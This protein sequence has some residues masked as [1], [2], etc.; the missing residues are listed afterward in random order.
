M[1]DLQTKLDRLTRDGE[2]FDKLE[3]GSVACYACGHTCRIA[4]GHRGFCKVRR[5]EN[6]MLKVPWGYVAGLQADPIEKK[7]FAHFFPGATALTYG[8]LGCNLHCDFCQ[9]W[10]T[11]QALRDPASDIS[12]EYIQAV[13]PEQIV[14]AAKRSR[15]VILASSYNEPLITSEWSHAVFS[16]AKSQGLRTVYVSNGFATPDVLEYM[17]PVVDGMKIDLKTMQAAQYRA[18][19]G[20]LSVVLDTISAARAL[21][22]WVEVVTLVIPGFNDSTEELWDAARA[23]TAVSADI[24]WHV[25]AFHPDYRKDATLPTPAST[26]QRAAEIGQEAGLQYVYAGNLPGRVGSLEDTHCPHCQKVLIHRRGY[27]ILDYSITPAG[28]CPACGTPIA[29]VWGEKPAGYPHIAAQ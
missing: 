18:L 16:L 1:P 11:S 8:M 28:A 15:A 6:G 3:S 4:E 5:N 9:N 13:S 14:A 17:R 20:D 21:G 23:I 12:G 24:P 26:L 27:I 22:L 19:G 7:P 25:T 2:L 29:G 10:L